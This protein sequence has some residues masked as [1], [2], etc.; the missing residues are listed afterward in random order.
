MR[1]AIFDVEVIDETDEV[2]L[3]REPTDPEGV[4]A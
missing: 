4:D 2:T 3:Y 1:S